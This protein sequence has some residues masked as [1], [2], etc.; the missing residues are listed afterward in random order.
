MTCW[1]CSTTRFIIGPQIN[2]AVK[3]ASEVRLGQICFG[4]LWEKRPCF[5]SWT[6]WPS[7]TCRSG[8]L[9]M[10]QVCL[11]QIDR[12]FTLVDIGV[13][14]FGSSHN[15]GMN[16]MPKVEALVRNYAGT[17]VPIGI[18]LAYGWLMTT[19]PSRGWKLS[20]IFEMIFRY[21]SDASLDGTWWSEFR[22]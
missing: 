19:N 18:S 12:G 11:R 8:R 3:E 1:G 14:P 21:L 4:R 9:R 6:F 5:N 20:N 2:L 17:V 7:K 10:N 22:H 15:C 13:F 16:V